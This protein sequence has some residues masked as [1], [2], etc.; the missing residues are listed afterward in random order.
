MGLILNMSRVIV[1]IFITIVTGA[2]VTQ[3]S[4]A[5][6]HWPTHKP[7]LWCKNR[8]CISITSWVIAN[9]PLKFTNFCYHGTRASL[10]EDWM[11]S[12]TGLTPNPLFGAKIWDLC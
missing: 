11:H 6:L 1:Q 10:E 4:L 3:I 2:G 12:I 7:L 9:F 8:R 5:Q